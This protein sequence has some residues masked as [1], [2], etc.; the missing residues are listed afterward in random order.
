MLKTIAVVSP[1]LP[2]FTEAL[3]LPLNASQHRNVTQKWFL[4]RCSCE[5]ANWYIA[6]RLGWAD[7][8]LWRVEAAEKFLMVLWLALACLEYWHE[9][10]AKKSEASAN[11]SG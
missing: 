6:E 7:C 2:R 4:K 8:R 5:V 11:R 3:T 9:L 1:E 10:T